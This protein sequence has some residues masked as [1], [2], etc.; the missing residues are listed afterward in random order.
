ME[1][2]GEVD[3]AELPHEVARRGVNELLADVAGIRHAERTAVDEGRALLST[4]TRK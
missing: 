1:L 4:G 3:A 2:M